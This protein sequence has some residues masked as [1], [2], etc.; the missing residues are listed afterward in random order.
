MYN[1]ERYLEA[2][3]ETLVSQTYPNLEIVICDNASTDAT[4]AIC[5]RFAARDAR[6]S[7]HRSQT[8]VGLAENFNRCRKLANRGRYFMWAASDDLRHPDCVRQCVEAMEAD[9]EAV[10]CCPQIEFIDEQG[11][12]TR[13]PMLRPEEE[14]IRPSGNTRLERVRG[15]TRLPA[16]FDF[17]GLI[18]RSALENVGP[19]PDMWCGDEVLMIDMALQ[20]R[21]IS[22]PNKLFSYRVYAVKPWPNVARSLV[23]EGALAPPTGNSLALVGMI[24]RF[25]ACRMGLGERWLLTVYLLAVGTILYAHTRKAVRDH[26]GASFAFAWHN[27]R[28]S[29]LAWLVV[30]AAGLAIPQRL[31]LA[32]GRLLRALRPAREV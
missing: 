25:H 17:Y 2:A 29:V 18:R 19:Y 16:W 26:L 1:G 21:F 12:P 20:G 10:M 13:C 7:Y 32:P 4:A 8:N 31:V 3:L 28:F 22:L 27:R 24:Q 9:P 11:R 6:I 15:M 14:S 23:P 30:V 5:E